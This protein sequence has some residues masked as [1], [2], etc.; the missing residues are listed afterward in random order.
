L[1]LTALVTVVIGP[2]SA[3]ATPDAATDLAGFTQGFVRVDDTDIHYV[4][5]GSGPAVLLLHGWPQTW[6]EWHSV[7]PGLARHHTV[8]A[9]DLPGLGSSSVPA[10]GFDKATTARRI[11]QAMAK[12]G[13]TKVTVVGHD[14]GVLV[15]YPYARDYPG[16]VDRLVVIELP[17]S[18]F[19]LEDFYAFDF[20]FT[21]NLAAFPIPETILDTG[22]VPSYHG[23]IFDYCHNCPAI[24]RERYYRAYAD[25]AKRHAGYEYYRAFP[26]DA[27]D[28]R[29][30][31]TP[32]T[33][34]VLV[35]GGEFS[36]GAYL[37]TFF[38]TVAPGARTVV[39]PGAR[40]FVPEENPQF[41][42]T[43]LEDFLA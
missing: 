10:G 34:P 32:L 42:V 4:K 3:V 12:L 37:G 33:L 25:P 28:N 41:L 15:A 14:V 20:H 17:L 18:G 5:G 30:H 31:L 38:T 9:V 11:H 8:V 21:F 27:A 24:D 6:W 29:A 26:A 19:G 36:F 1:I 40:H 35:V 39:V 7:M 23:M 2:P 22:D 16:D 13:I 43:T